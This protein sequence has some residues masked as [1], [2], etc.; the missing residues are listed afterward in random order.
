MLYTDYTA[1]YYSTLHCIVLPLHCSLHF[2]AFCIYLHHVLCCTLHFTVT[3]F[4]MHPALRCCRHFTAPWTSL[5]PALRW[6]CTALHHATLH[7]TALS[8]TKNSVHCSSL[9]CSALTLKYTVIQC[10]V[11]WYTLHCVWHIAL[12]CPF[13]VLHCE[14]TKSNSMQ[15]GRFFFTKFTTQSMGFFTTPDHPW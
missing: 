1:L 4:L 6:P 15:R 2:T 8:S 5:H 10:T 14:F 7:F 12:Q 3:C 11:Q 13:T 9:H